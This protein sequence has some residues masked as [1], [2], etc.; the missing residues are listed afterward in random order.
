MPAKLDSASTMRIGSV[1]FPE[2]LLNALRGGQLVVF[3]G[4]GVSMGAPAR[5]PSFRK[6]AEKVAEGTGKS[7]TASETDDQFLGRLKEDGVRVHQRATETLQ[8]DNLKPNALHR[9]LLRLFQEKDDPVRVVTTNFDCLFERAAEVEDLFKN[10]PKVF[11]APALPPGIRFKGI[12]RLHGS[13]KE[14]EEMVLTHRDFGRAYLTEED[15]WARRFLVSLFANHTVLFVGYSHNDTIMT[16]LTPSLPPDGG[17][18]RF[19]LVGSTSNDLDRWRRMGIEPIVFPQEN[20]DDFTGLDRGVE[21]LADFRRRGVIGWQQEIA[22]IAKGEPPMIDGEDSHTLDHALKDVKLTQ[23]FVRAVTSP[24]WIGWL[25]HRGYLKRLFA[26]G[27]LEEQDRILCEW[28]AV[29]FARTH[30]DELFSVILRYHGRL[31]G[32]FW[33]EL[34]R[35]LGHS[36]GNPLDPQTLSRWVHILMNCVPMDVDEY[37]LLNLMK[38]CTEAGK[39]QSLLQV[40]D[41]ITTRL[42]QFLPGCER[43][44][45]DFWNNTM[46][47]LWEQCLRSNFQHIAHALL[48]RTTMRLEHRHSA[49][50]AW[51]SQDNNMMSGDNCSR[52]AIESHEQNEYP[53]GSAIDPLIDVARDCLEWLVVD[54]PMTVK[55]WCNRFVKSDSPPLLRRLAIHATNARQDLSVDDKIAWLLEHYDV[56]EY[57]AKHEIF[58]MAANVYPEASS[59]QKEALIQAIS[60]YQTPAEINSAVYSIYHRFNWFQWLHKADLN[61]SLLEAELARIRSQYPEFR[62]RE[63]PDFNSWFSGAGLILGPWSAEKLLAKPAFEWLPNLLGYQPSEEEEILSRQSRDSLLLA[64]CQAAERDPS[65]GLDLADAMAEKSAWESDLW[66]WVVSVWTREKTDLDK[67]CTR[68]VLFHLSTSKLHQPRNA[69]VIVDVLNRLI[70][71]ADTADLKEWL[72]TLHKIAIAI[73]PHAAAFEDKPIEN[74]RDRDWFQ[75]A[76]NHPSGKLAE[77]WLHS[78]DKWYNQQDEPPQ[79]LNLGY[80]RALNTIIEDNGI[81]GKLGRTILASQFRFL[82]QVDSDWTK[83]HLLPLFDTK[84]EEEFSCAWDG[85]LT[86]GRLSLLAGELLKEKCIGGL[87]RAIQDFPKNRLTRFIQFYILVISYLVNND[88]DKWIYTFFNQT[89]EKPE[90]KHMFTTEVGRLLR[91]LDE[92]SQNE[93]WNVWLRDYWNNRLQGIPCPLDDAEIATMFE[94]AIHLQGVFPEAVDMAL[95]MGPVPLELPLYLQ[96]SHNIG[97]INLIN[98]YPVEL[99]QLLIHLGKCQT[100]PWFWYQDSQILHQLLEKDLPEDLKQELQETILRIKIS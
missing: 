40:Y 84:D 38:H 62:P 98:R 54:D 29:R 12:V 37:F 34:L 66:T 97:K 55:N 13:V 75:K 80:R 90:L 88:K 99:A 79:A 3:A 64:V 65:W 27:K 91:R 32:Y 8:P 5:L 22:G 45:N 46:K 95:Q 41:V 51:S 35:E 73:H 59:Q 9:N 96:L 82:H 83:N 69:G 94:W 19:A 70:R 4:A 14:P 61:C 21:G 71:N 57:E 44:R 52:P 81:P 10:K 50:V 74:L 77:F 17:E 28:L 47:E 24:K 63:H 58:R 26:E 42:V 11:E 2:S 7:I 87:Q 67:A 86:G 93:W 31:N 1:D 68:R 39:F 20:K 49:R 76:I 56:N 16:Y 30:S 15:G 60:Q 89:Q 23:F 85:Y 78:I 43:S 72:D 48:E 53:Y 33:N 6:L 18:K 36:E 100:S 25:D 92:S